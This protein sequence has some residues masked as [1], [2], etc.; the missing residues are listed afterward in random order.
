MPERDRE[1][2]PPNDLDAVLDKAGC[3]DPLALAIPSPAA[4]PVLQGIHQAITAGLGRPH[5]W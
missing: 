1:T 2:P 4:G 3:L 5:R